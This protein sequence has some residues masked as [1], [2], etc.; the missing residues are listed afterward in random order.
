MDFYV[1]WDHLWLYNVLLRISFTRDNLLNISEKKNI[2][3]QHLVFFSLNKHITWAV[4]VYVHVCTCNRC[5]RQKMTTHTSAS[6]DGKILPFQETKQILKKPQVNKSNV[7]ISYYLWFSKSGK[8]TS[9]GRMTSYGR[10]EMEKWLLK[11]VT[12]THRCALSPHLTRLS[13]GRGQGRGIHYTQPSP[14]GWTVPICIQVS[15]ICP[16]VLQWIHITVY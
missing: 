10:K 9:L 14:S 12:W 11:T 8:N 6:Q 16:S 2:Q 15:Y 3:R 4:E 7:S 1:S 5:Y 13:G